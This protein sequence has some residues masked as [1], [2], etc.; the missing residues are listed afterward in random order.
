MTGVTRIGHVRQLRLD[1]DQREHERPRLLADAI[2]P[3][4]AELL[5]ELDQ[6]HQLCEL[7]APERARLYRLAGVAAHRWPE[8]EDA[9]RRALRRAAA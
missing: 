1:L 9:V 7:S 8:Y 2:G 6:A 5:P 4:L 3:V